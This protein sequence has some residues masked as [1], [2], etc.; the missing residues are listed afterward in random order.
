MLEFKVYIRSC[1][2]YKPFWS[3]EN[4]DVSRII[5]TQLEQE[6]GESCT[7]LSWQLKGI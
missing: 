2:A 1:Q 4:L 6:Y 3:I 5:E 7:D